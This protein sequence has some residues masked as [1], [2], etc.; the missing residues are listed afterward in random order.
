[1]VQAGLFM[2]GQVL[3]RITAILPLSIHLA[4]QVYI[5]VF[6]PGRWYSADQVLCTVILIQGIIEALCFVAGGQLLGHAIMH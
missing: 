6:Y 3:R 4:Q 5:Q 1:M 2:F